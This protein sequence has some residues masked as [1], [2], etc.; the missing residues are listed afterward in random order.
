MKM[1]KKHWE[2]KQIFVLIVAMFKV[3]VVVSIGM[4]AK[5]I[6]RWTN[7]H[8]KEYIKEEI[9]E[10]IKEFDT[11]FQRDGQGRMIQT[12]GGFLVAIRPN[13]SWV[14]TFG[15][16]VHEMTHVTQYLLKDR[17]IPLSQDTD[18]VHAYLVEYLVTSAAR[19]ML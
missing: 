8:A 6:L 4:S 15:T 11:D 1:K 17:S 12:G 2:E 16:L 9:A 13:P 14:K 3:D 18:E 10:Q 19:K 7:R 5:E